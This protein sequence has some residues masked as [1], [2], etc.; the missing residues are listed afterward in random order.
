MRSRTE[1]P[2]RMP[3]PLRGPSPDELFEDWLEDVT[4]I[5]RETWLAGYQARYVGNPP[6]PKTP[7]PDLT[8]PSTKE[9]NWELPDRELPPGWRK[10]FH[11][12]G[13]RPCRRAA[14]ILTRPVQRGETVLPTEVL[15]KINGQVIDEH[16][17][18]VCGSCGFVLY[19]L[20]SNTDLDWAPHI[21]APT[22]TEYLSFA[23]E[24]TPVNGRHPVDAMQDFASTLHDPLEPEEILN[25][26]QPLAIEEE[27]E[28][29]R[30][31]GSDL[32][33]F[34]QDLDD[35]EEDQSQV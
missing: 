21:V 7:K 2:R 24:H 20:A 4:P 3:P 31:L 6:V 13:E 14:Y 5:L 26:A 15:R 27:E 25:E 9:R 28:A 16:D 10:V 11:M 35:D 29:L 32:Q 33:M 30:K 18:T 19:Q 22:T 12:R 23:D 17:E 8:A 1:P 34:T